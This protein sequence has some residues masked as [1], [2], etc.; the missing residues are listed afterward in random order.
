MFHGPPDTVF[1]HVSQTYLQVDLFPLRPKMRTRLTLTIAALA[2]IGSAVRPEPAPAQNAP[3]EL[4]RL[5]PH[6]IVEQVLN[7]RQELGLTE[8]QIAS[9]DE[10]HATIRDEKHQYSHAGGKPHKT[11]HET[12]IT[13]NQ[14]YADAMAV[15]TPEQRGK[16]MPLLTTLPQT[17]RLPA[18]FKGGKPHQI[19]ERFLEQ[20][21]KL[22]LGESQVR[23]L[24]ELHIMIRDE[25]HRYSHSG[26]KP[27]ETKHQRMIT[28]E[29]AFADAM[30]VLSPEQRLR[31]VQ[32]FAN[33]AS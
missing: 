6:Q 10:L 24:E 8:A 14:A 33:D 19:P 26:G 27:H 22:A 5:K 13:R 11:T 32:L 9:L 29:L 23:Q 18:R 4:E 25:K 1:I 15:L 30:A 31:A 2:T 16:A 17:V 28:R 3:A 21:E 12:M 20:R 7:L